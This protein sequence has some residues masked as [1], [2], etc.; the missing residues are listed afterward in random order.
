MTVCLIRHGKT[1][2]NEKHL[3]CGS[4]DLPL[5][6]KGREELSQIH[7]DIKN[8][9]FLTSG[10]KRTDETLKILV[11]GIP[12]DTDLRFREVDFGI[13]EMHSYK[14]LKDTQEYQAWLAGDNEANVPPGGES[15]EKMKQRVLGA[16]TEI[17]EDTCIITHG[18]VIA[19]IMEYLF[20]EENKIRY[21]WQPKNGY[22]YEIQGREYKSIP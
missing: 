21:D 11:G 12:F 20:P 5:S 7:Y 14:Q 9:R 19:A 22:G 8:V 1:E 15:G 18:G 3:Y 16:F 4:T 17:E 13:F 2:A 10:M 6:E